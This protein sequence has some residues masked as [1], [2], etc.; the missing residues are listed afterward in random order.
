MLFSI[1]PF[2]SPNIPRNMSIPR[3]NAN[4]FATNV[5]AW[6]NVIRDVGSVEFR[7]L[8]H[9]LQTVSDLDAKTREFYEQFATESALGEI[10]VTFPVIAED[11]GETIFAIVPQAGYNPGRIVEWSQLPPGSVR[12][13]KV[14][15]LFKEL[16]KA[17]FHLLNR[18][19]WGNTG[20]T[21]RTGALYPDLRRILIG[22][23]ERYCADIN[24][25]RPNENGLDLSFDYQAANIV[26]NIE[27]IAESIPSKLGKLLVLTVNPKEKKKFM[28]TP[29]YKALNGNLTALNK[30]VMDD[31]CIDN[32]AINVAEFNR[33]ATMTAPDTTAQTN[34]TPENDVDSVAHQ[35]NPQDDDYDDIAELFMDTEEYLLDVVETDEL[36]DTIGEDH[37]ESPPQ[38]LT[39]SQ[40]RR[41]PDLIPKLIQDVK[42]LQFVQFGRAIPYLA[43]TKD[44]LA[45]VPQ[46]V[47]LGSVYEKYGFRVFRTVPFS[48]RWN[49]PFVQMDTTLLCKKILKVDFPS[50]ITNEKVLKLWNRFL[51]MDDR[52]FKPRRAMRFQGTVRFGRGTVQVLLDNSNL[53]GNHL[54]EE[55]KKEVKDQREEESK[56]KKESRKKNSINYFQHHM[57][58]LV[59]A[60]NIVAIDLNRWSILA[61]K[62]LDLIK[63]SKRL[64]QEADLTETRFWE[65]TKEVIAEGHVYNYTRGQMETECGTREFRSSLESLKKKEPDVMNAEREL[66]TLTGRT[67]DTKVLRFNARLRAKHRPTLL[68]FY[69]R[70]DVQRLYMKKFIKTQK[71][72]DNLFKTLRN[73]YSEKTVYMVGDY[74]DNGYVPKGQDS[75]ATRIWLYRF[76]RYKLNAYAIDECRTSAVCPRCLGDISM[77]V[78]IQDGKRLWAVSG[79]PNLTCVRHNREC[80]H[81]DNCPPEGCPFGQCQSIT[82]GFKFYNRD[83]LATSNMLFIIAF[84]M[85]HEVRPFMY[86][87]RELR[88]AEGQPTTLAEQLN[89]LNDER[90]VNLR[91]RNPFFPL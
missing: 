75:A 22:P 47:R 32:P 69:S 62:N 58:D 2:P 13:K 33:L 1:T 89:R 78:K 65:I 87:R 73:I 67:T 5:T 15:D 17:I 37:L 61:C 90:P 64:A 70:S 48:S 35:N 82:S 45:F 51:Y 6:K 91:R 77:N 85:E 41:D 84:M 42:S 24:H 54:S 88:T 29:D 3:T 12:F 27:N 79:C 36:V 11:K 31:F 46:L 49:A 40:T 16:I 60:D 23:L 66:T 80:L 9:F 59:E 52:V 43:K 83:E 44:A 30:W 68:G 86:L 19:D 14:Y 34:Q 56:K 63:L 21:V 7:R 28:S 38:P 81:E 50:P 20:R 72:F 74:S 53:R 4:V 39:V 55:D 76:W 10:E 57:D 8:V 18:R 26:Q 71:A 25:Q